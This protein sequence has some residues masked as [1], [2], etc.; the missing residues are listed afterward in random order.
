[1]YVTASSVG[2][3]YSIR[4]QFDGVLASWDGIILF[5]N[6]CSTKLNTVLRE[7]AKFICE[8]PAIRDT[9]MITCADL[10]AGALLV[11]LYE[12]R[13]QGQECGFTHIAIDHE[14]MSV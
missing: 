2:T 4:R 3:D 8:P 6:F 13:T 12:P 11:V 5:N 7:F 9:W 10:F 14:A 1:M